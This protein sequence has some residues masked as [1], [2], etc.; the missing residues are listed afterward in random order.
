MSSAT[1]CLGEGVSPPRCPGRLGMSHWTQR[2]LQGCLP[3]FLGLPFPS[4]YRPC[5]LLNPDP[6]LTLSLSSLCLLSPSP[7]LF[8]AALG[9]WYAPRRLTPKPR[10]V[11]KLRASC[12]TGCK[13][14]PGRRKGDVQWDFTTSFYF[15]CSPQGPGCFA[16]P[17]LLQPCRGQK[18]MCTEGK[19]GLPIPPTP[20]GS[21][22]PARRGRLVRVPGHV[23]LP[24][25]CSHLCSGDNG[26]RGSR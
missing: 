3:H 25:Q 5:S 21:P 6:A 12:L 19:W 13:L 9:L 10:P 18:E 23:A 22:A 20:S 8:T 16:A 14:S 26:R 1:A 17:Q 11:P 2:L 15:P 4:Q 7:P 24:P